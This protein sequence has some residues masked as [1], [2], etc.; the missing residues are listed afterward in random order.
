MYDGNFLR[1]PNE[2]LD[3]CR[4]PYDP[5]GMEQPFEVTD[6]MGRP[7][8]C[9]NA[10]PYKKML[11]RCDRMTFRDETGREREKH[12]LF[13]EQRGNHWQV[14]GALELR[15]SSSE[16]KLSFISCREK[17]EYEGELA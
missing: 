4:S 7:S 6:Y 14:Y 1:Y 13:D 17:L 9:P 5:A 10:R 3:H 2:L 11:E 16:M 8:L 15:G 12:C